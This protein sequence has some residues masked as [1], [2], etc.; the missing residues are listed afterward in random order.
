MLPHRPGTYSGKK[1]PKPVKLKTTATSKHAAKPKAKPVPVKRPR[2]EDQTRQFTGVGKKAFAKPV[3]ELN[4]PGFRVTELMLAKAR[5]KRRQARVLATEV[6]AVAKPM[7]GVVPKGKATLAMDSQIETAIGWA[8]QSIYQGAFQQGVTFL[9]Y[10]YLAEL[11][12]RAEYRRV[13]E[14]IAT[15]M[16]RKWIEIKV[17]TQDLED[18]V[19]AAGENVA[20]E[21]GLNDKPGLPGAVKPELPGAKPVVKGKEAPPAM[22]FAP[23]ALAQPKPEPAPGAE[24]GQPGEE[25]GEEEDPLEQA[26]ADLKAKKA[27][28]KEKRVHELEEEMKRLNVQG[29]F[30][31]IAEQDGFFGRAHLFIEVNKANGEDPNLRDELKIPIG[32]GAID[33]KWSKGKITKGSVDRLKTVEAIWC[34]PANYNSNNPLAENWY[35]PSMW[36]VQGMEVHASRL[37]TFVGREVPDMLKPAYSFGG[38]SLSQMV[39][40]TVMN[41]LRTR[42]SVS[43]IVHAFSVF[44]L[45]TTMASSIQDD[46]DELFKRADFFNAVRD[47]TGV[48]MIDKESEEF[49]NVSAPISGLDALQAQSQEH[50]CSVSG[51][52]LVKYT[53]I[54]PSGLNATSEFEIASFYDWVKA[55]QIALFQANLDRVFHIAQLNIWGEVDPDIYYEFN[56]LAEQT[57]KDKADTR[58]V[59]ADT[60][61]VLIDKGVIT[62]EEVRGRLSKDVDGP[63]AG[64]PIEEVP[65]PPDQGMMDGFDPN[66]EPGE[67]DNDN[68]FPPK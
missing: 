1:K 37:L 35:K 18:E 6:F 33:D 57:E 5:G 31:E 55:F 24:P 39:Q 64:I 65:E 43:D 9:G 46:G 67:N 19:D 10:P 32:T 36:F 68:P 17:R 28:E 22:D 26:K 52:P 20:N 60:D 30:K 47:N 3:V 48:M 54:S 53:G 56:P 11:A 59:E 51:L 25:P 62:P 4:R 12:Q 40:P 49:A 27:K 45:S 13:S 38:L 16:T 41:W 66:A 42:Q 58:K 8:A 50:I 23:P 21:L 61:G 63:Y 7:P 44:V 2:A 15:E 29:C 14:V 34:Y